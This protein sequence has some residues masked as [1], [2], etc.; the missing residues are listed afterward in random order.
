MD[1]AQA[2]REIAKLTEKIKKYDK[3]YFQDAKPLVSDYTY[4][5]LVARLKKLEER[6]PTYQKPD[7]PT[8][9]VSE[10]PL[11]Y[12][13]SVRHRTPMYSLGNT[14]EEAEVVQFIQRIQKKL[15]NES[16]D[17]FCELKLDGVALSIIYEYGKLRRM[18]TRG[19]GL[20]GDDITFNAI[21]FNNLQ[22]TL[23]HPNIPAHIEVRGEVIMKKASFQEVNAIYEKNGQTLLANPRNAAAGLLRNQNP[24]A[25]FYKKPPLAFVPYALLQNEIT[26][27]SQEQ[28]MQ[29]TQAWGFETLPTS[30]HCKN[31]QEIMDYIHYWDKHKQDLPMMIDGVVIKVNNLQQQ[32]TLGATAK[33][34]RWAVAYKYK[35]DGCFSTLK[36]VTFHVGRT[37]VVTPVA[38]FNPILLEGTRVQHASLYNAQ[39]IEN[40]DLH[41]GDAIFIEKG[42]G[43]IPKVVNVDFSKRKPN[44]Q[45]I[46]FI[47]HCPDCGSKLLHL[48][49]EAMHYCPNTQQCPAQLKGTLAHFVSRKA[50]NIQTIGLKTIDLLFDKKLLQ[51]PVDLFKLRM[52]DIQSLEGFGAKS[53]QNILTNIEQAK[54]KPFANVLFGLGIRHVGYTTAKILVAY[55]STI[56]A[57]MTASEEALLAIPEIGPTIATSLLQYFQAPYHLQQIQGLRH[58]GLTFEAKVR[59]IT[60][61][62]PLSDK[63]FVV[64]GIFPN[65]NREEMQAYI[66]SKGGKTVTSISKKVDFLVIG[67]KPSSQKLAKA[68]ALNIPTIYQERLEEMVQSE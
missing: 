64:S 43:I 46:T 18:V 34:P 37:G 52:E 62:G 5:Q 65:H 14:Y 27:T 8:R 20:R 16:I 4:D 68:E 6:F 23:E 15:S 49:G 53:A 38:T 2:K 63:T 28:A 50:L 67:Q 59:N 54:E 31:L 29:Q 26:I 44:Q 57:L 45:R 10:R 35:P 61:K 47:T 51:T 3:A 41:R 9:F 55:F 66:Q 22:R 39:S 21:L 25:W 32:N 12:M 40:L 30:K 24:P 19:D 17:F 7:S 1:K 42:G 11:I 13:T 58:A 33:S 36:K 60:A 48:P 56:D